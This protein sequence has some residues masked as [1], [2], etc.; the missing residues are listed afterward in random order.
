MRRFTVL[1]SELTVY[2]DKIVM[3]VSSQ[4]HLRRVW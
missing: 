2:D 3:T 1:R 4:I